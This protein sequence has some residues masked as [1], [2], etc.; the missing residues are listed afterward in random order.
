MGLR[1]T[2]PVLVGRREE[3][4]RLAWA[5]EVGVSGESAV[6]LVAGEA[7]VGKTRLVGELAARAAERGL[8]VAV[9]RCIEFGETIWP[10][11]PLREILAR[12]AVELDAESLERVLGG[13]R[14]VLGQLVPELGEWRSDGTR[15]V[16]ERL[17][18][19]VVGVFERLAR[20]QPLL[21]VFEDLHWADAST[22]SLFSLLARVGALGPVLLVGTYRS[23]EL[24]RR[25][26]LR[27]LLAEL[28]RSSRTARIELRPLDGAAT[29]ELLAA[30]DAEP[31]WAD[32][33]HRRS[34]GNPFY[35]EELV[36]ARLAGVTGLPETL[37]DVVLA[38][39]SLL[40]EVSTGVLRIVAATGST[41]QAVLAA[42]SGL[43]VGVLDATLG[44]LWDESLLI[45]DGDDIRFRHE[46]VR[47]VFYDDLAPGE[48][49]PLH[50]RIAGTLEVLRPERLGEITWHWSSAFD[51]PRALTTSIAAGR[52][53]LGA[54]AAAEAEGHFSR[55]LEL[56]D[57][58]EC[59][60]DLAGI[61]HAALLIETA[62]AAEHGRHLDRAIELAMRA[63]GEL[64]GVDPMR[65][66]E[67]WLLLRDLYRFAGRRDECNAALKRALALI[68]TSPPSRA[69]AEA[70]ADASIGHWYT[71]HPA[72]SLVLAREAVEMAELLGDPDT[73]VFA[74]NAL[75]AALGLNGDLE[76]ALASAQSTVDMCGVDVSPDSALVAFNG[77]CIVLFDLGRFTE[78]PAV[79]ERAVGLAR[80]TGLAGPRGG[81]SACTGSPRSSP[82]GGG[83][84]PNEGS[85]S[86]AI[87]TTPT[88]TSSPAIGARRS[89]A[90]AGSTRPALS[91]SGSAPVWRPATG[92]RTWPGWGSASSPSTP[93]S[94]MPRGSLRSSMTCW[95]DRC[96]DAASASPPRDDRWP[97]S[98]ITP[99]PCPPEQTVTRWL[100]GSPPPPD[101]ST[102][103]NRRERP[104]HGVPAGTSC[105]STRPMPS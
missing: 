100:D 80:R 14:D 68:P 11:A 4:G 52:Q 56:W 61:D 64:D 7:G 33:I 54:G 45:V 21:L 97:R 90:R 26:P 39:S 1:L 13:A 22:R 12:L 51:L 86:T 76:A 47:E 77:L 35:I 62:V 50:A 5:A 34:E 79:S 94:A 65:E 104:G 67:V 103:W 53:A 38:R 85:R 8:R 98:P 15:V 29:I 24:H 75:S 99:S 48:R 93:P 82:S 23:D 105:T 74:R 71:N 42:V 63:S 59:A 36:A 9:G 78:I 28:A 40:D 87:C 96:E 2:S 102:G 81:W 69:R 55:A 57:S 43:K 66:G 101:G 95:N 18:E 27:P 72:E 3:L 44:R 37:R 58:V 32:E 31:A 73:L 46:L 41:T 19:L 88:L 83:T 10:M 20:R 17:G 70:L 6:V 25:H 91:W 92:P 89:C 30:L 16:S 60:D 49:A 84:R